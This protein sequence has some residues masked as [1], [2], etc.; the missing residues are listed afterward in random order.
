MMKAVPVA[1][2]LVATT[3]G[4]YGALARTPQTSA[5]VQVQQI[6][7][8]AV[9]PNQAL[10]VGDLE[11][12]DIYTSRGERLGSVKRAVLNV[13]DGRTFLVLEHGGIVGL[14][15]KEFP[16]PVEKVYLQGGRLVVPE[17]TDAELEA[18]ADWDVYNQK[19][20][21]MADSEIIN[22]NRR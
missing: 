5:D 8:N 20:R 13:T 2:M 12:R 16:L 22:V 17:L 7:G 21:E 6:Q 9:L 14:G 18:V 11:Q 10:R 19:Y 1:V 15:E 3:A 4:P